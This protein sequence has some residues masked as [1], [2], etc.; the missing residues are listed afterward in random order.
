MIDI[1]QR[2]ERLTTIG[3]LNLSTLVSHD[4]LAAMIGVCNA[5]LEQDFGPAWG[6]WAALA[7]VPDGP[8]LSSYAYQIVLADNID[9]KDALGYHFL[10]AGGIVSGPV[11]VRP[12]LD[13]GGVVLLDEA[14]LQRPSVLSVLSHEVLEMLADPYANAWAIGPERTEGALYAYEI[15]DATESDQY[16]QE[17]RGTRGAVSNFVL[18]NWFDP[19]APPGTKVD[20]LGK[21]PGP[22]QIAP[23]G[24]M[25]VLGPGYQ[26]QNIMG[27]ECRPW[28]R[29]RQ[30][31][32]A[33]S[34]K[35]RAHAQH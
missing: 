35:R 1:Q 3:V 20:F 2:P 30:L 14:N 15:C 8:A 22:F 9:Q 26:L 13:E 19:D 7:D 18:P 24:Y 17:L 11:G 12:V 31:T 25:M 6:I 29:E 28:K 32:S 21:C 16:V 33:R 23:G 27:A 5:Q 10:T 34:L 4:D